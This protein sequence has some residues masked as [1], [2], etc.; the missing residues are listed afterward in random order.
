MNSYSRFSVSP[1]KGS[2]PTRSLL[3]RGG[4]RIRAGV[5]IGH[6]VLAERSFFSLLRPPRLGRGSFS[7]FVEFL[8]HPV[9]LFRF[10]RR[11][12]RSPSRAGPFSWE[13][14]VGVG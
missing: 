10:Y 2:R 12:G 8:L 6:L 1:A 14:V 5:V 7:Q 11:M 9:L 4:Y 13:P 3:D